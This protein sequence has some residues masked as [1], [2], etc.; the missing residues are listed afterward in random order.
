MA[1]LSEAKD[2]I[3]TTPISTVVSFYHPITKRGANFEGI[4]PF[5]GDSHPSLKI[6]DSKG[7]YKCFA[8]GAAGDSI[9]FVQDKINVEFIDAVKDIAQHLGINIEESKIKK[10]P[11][12]EMGLRVLQAANKIYRKIASENTPEVFKKFVKDRNLSEESIK[13]FQIGFA[14]GNSGLTK[15]LESI[16]SNE[17]EL[18]IASAKDIGIIRNNKNA[19]GHYD[20]FRRRVMF[21]IWDHSGKV[22]GFSSRAVLKDQVPKYLNSGESF[23]FDKGN[24][25][26]GFNLAKTHI[27]EQDSVII[28]E[29]NMDVISLHQFGFRN[30]VATMGV[31]LSLNSIKLLSNMTKNI[32][33]AMDSDPAGIKAMTKINKDLLEN[34]IIAKFIDFTPSKDPDEFLNSF[35]RLE[36]QKR[37]EDAPSFIDYLINK[38]IPTPIPQN[39]DQK[40]SI[41]RSVFAIILPI[42]SQLLANEK[43][44]GAAKQLNLKSSEE[45][46]IE[47]FKQFKN[48]TRP[49]RN[50]SQ[51]SVAVEEASAENTPQE[52]KGSELKIDSSQKPLREEILLLKTLTLNPE[53]I[54]VNQIPEILDKIQHFEVKRIVQWLKDIYLEIDESELDLF[55]KQK[56]QEPLPDEI[57]KVLASS[58]LRSGQVKLDKKISEKVMGDLLIKL[59]IAALKKERDQLR[60]KQLEAK[61]DEDGLAIINEIQLIEQQLLTLRNK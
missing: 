5:H 28:V 13:N 33:L 48:N 34:D 47:E 43:A 31:A 15:Y 49:M 26:Y 57:K 25:L 38:S 41:L 21:P 61:T 39:V 8:C 42:K 54:L 1:S 45:D 27:R 19:Q 55:I 18:A 29:G 4:C 24:I 17:K 40:L 60:V 9:K 10:N 53:C 46:V 2:I 7:I 20:F 12:F 23:V 30:S 3:K 44:I 32:F 16:P 36:L 35:G 52:D 58:L 37:I 11:K 59:N 50:Y 56:L 22:R 51:A 6:N 14:P